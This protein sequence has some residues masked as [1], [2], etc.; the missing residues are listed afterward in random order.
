MYVST[1]MESIASVYSLDCPS[2][3]NV[4][5]VGAM[6]EPRLLFLIEATIVGVISRSFI[7]DPH[8]GERY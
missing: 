4:K 3:N 5:L 2:S 1:C 6:S 8:Q 7:G